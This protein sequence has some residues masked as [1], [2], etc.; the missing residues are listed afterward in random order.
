MKSL[1]IILNLLPI[2]VLAQLN[3]V[4]NLLDSRTEKAHKLYASGFYREALKLYEEEYEHEFNTEIL[5][6][7]GEVHFKLGE[8]KQASGYYLALLQTTE[9]NNVE[10]HLKLALSLQSIG[11]YEKSKKWFSSYL[12]QKP[13][14]PIAINQFNAINNLEPFTQNSAYTKID[15]LLINTQNNEF[16]ST[17]YNGTLYYSASKPQHQVIQHNYLRTDEPLTELFRISN[18]NPSIK[19]LSEKIKLPHPFTSNNGPISIHNNILIVTRNNG[20]K[21]PSENNHLGLY[22]FEMI[23]NTVVYQKPFAYNNKQYNV[24]HPAFTISG[25]TLFFSSD[26]PGGFGGLDI[27]Y[28]VKNNNKWGPPVNA[29]EKINTAGNEIFPFPKNKH[30]YFA[31]NGHPGLGGMDI[32]KVPFPYKSKN[33]L[34]NLGAP[35]NSGYDD[36]GICFLEDQAIIS[37]N[38]RE[39]KGKD[40]LYLITTKTPNKKEIQ[41]STNTIHLVIKDD[42]NGMPL[43]NTKVRMI[44]EHTGIVKIGFTDSNGLLYDTLKTGEYSILF[45][46]AGYEVHERTIWIEDDQ[47]FEASITLKPSISFE[48]IEPDSVMFEFNEYKLKKSAEDELDKLTDI[49]T[50][51]PQLKLEIH[52]HTDSRGKKAYNKQLSTLRANSAANYLVENGVSTHRI[53]NIEGLG[54]EHLLNGC[55]DGVPCEEE[56]HAKNRRIEFI[57]V[58]GHETNNKVE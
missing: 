47:Y 41:P 15:N 43:D 4:Y 2:M 35:I 53:I 48:Y 21:K 25:D 30:I 29:G 5:K 11:E 3:T 23:N 10:E 45:K 46:K 44:D 52:A 36:F 37:S 1:L 17:V 38:R 56:E 51:Y 14:D 16:G 12:A 54:E 19:Q 13:E 57:L 42:L 34:Y 31:S 7:L 9:Y 27:F 39:G 6:K 55:S 33:Q 22:F 40:D 49:L 50:K 24:A 32:F 8:Y 58:S 18:F 26:M 28:S 20:T